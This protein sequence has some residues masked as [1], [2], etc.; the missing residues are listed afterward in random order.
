MGVNTYI[1]RL[2]VHIWMS[3]KESNAI[4]PI[5]LYS[6]DHCGQ[7]LLLVLDCKAVKVTFYSKLGDIGFV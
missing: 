3:K 6:E 1:V 5:M 2:C 7:H 4:N